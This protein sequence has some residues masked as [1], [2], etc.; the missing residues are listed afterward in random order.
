MTHQPT[1]PTRAGRVSPLSVRRPWVTARARG[2]RQADV[3]CTNEHICCGRARAGRTRAARPRARAGEGEA[4]NSPP[5][6]QLLL[7]KRRSGLGRLGEARGGWGPLARRPLG[8]GSDA[9]RPA[10]PQPWV[11]P[12]LCFGGVVGVV[13][14]WCCGGFWL[15]D[16]I[17]QWLYFWKAPRGRLPVGNDLYEWSAL[18]GGCHTEI[19]FVPYG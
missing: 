3:L 6:A 7:Q 16:C 18:L 8:I 19:N 12:L 9:I 2:A 4:A 13:G 17:S 5:A 1:T 14:R 11:R 10:A 15:S